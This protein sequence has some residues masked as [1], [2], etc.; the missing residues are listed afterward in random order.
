[1]H[2]G[3]PRQRAPLDGPGSPTETTAAAYRPCE[4]MAVAGDTA[5][6]RRMT[7]V[8]P[9]SRSFTKADLGLFERLLFE[10]HGPHGREIQ[11]DLGP[12]ALDLYDAIAARVR[13]A[14]DEVRALDTW[15]PDEID[16]AAIRVVGASLLRHHYEPEFQSITGFTFAQVEG[17]RAKAAS[18]VRTRVTGAGRVSIIVGERRIQFPTGII[19]DT[20]DH[21]RFSLRFPRHRAGS[22]STRTY[23]TQ[24]RYDATL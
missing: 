16:L 4:R 22:A 3:P 7:L 20:Q 24:T 6:R 15:T 10:I 5:H 14:L 1:M 8:R 12:A 2:G 18:P 13:V 9:T 19:R 11:L 23:A 21:S 17:L